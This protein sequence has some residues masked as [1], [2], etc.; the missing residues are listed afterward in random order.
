[1]NFQYLQAEIA[2][3]KRS[4]PQMR[5]DNNVFTIMVKEK[6]AAQMAIGADYPHPHSRVTLLKMENTPKPIIDA[7]KVGRD[8]RVK[9]RR[10]YEVVLSE[11]L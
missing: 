6:I 3:L 4:Y 9:Q 5:L 7:L 11:R 2:E 10:D 1:M 8:R